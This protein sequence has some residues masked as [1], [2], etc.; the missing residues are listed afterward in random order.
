VDNKER[1]IAWE[2]RTQAIE[3]EWQK[4]HAEVAGRVS[5]RFL[6]TGIDAAKEL[7]KDIPQPNDTETLL[8][9]LSHTTLAFGEPPDLTGTLEGKFKVTLVEMIDLLNKAINDE[10]S[11][12]LRYRKY[13]ETIRAQY[14]EALA[15]HWYEHAEQERTHAQW[16]ARKVSALGGIPSFAPEAPPDL[17]DIGEIIDL[18]LRKE[19]EGIQTWRVILD[20]AGDNSFKHQIEDILVQETEHADDLWQNKPRT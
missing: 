1:R 12:D 20:A 4:R 18:L 13:A 16:A 17:T 3:E 14:R 19:Q 8:R 7:A 15:D 2:K 5:Q 11:Q 10:C 9:K 6:N